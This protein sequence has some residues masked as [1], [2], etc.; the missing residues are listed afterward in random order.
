VRHAKD[1]MVAGGKYYSGD[2][3]FE[4]PSKTVNLN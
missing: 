3:I 2:V 1:E 4:V